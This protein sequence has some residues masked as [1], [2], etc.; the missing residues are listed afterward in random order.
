MI[1]A[2]ISKIILKIFILGPHHPGNIG[3]PD[4]DVLV[5]LSREMGICPV[6]LAGR[7]GPLPSVFDV[8]LD[9]RDSLETLIAASFRGFMDVFRSVNLGCL[10]GESRTWGSYDGQ[11]L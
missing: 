1:P 4:I 10:A 2:W 11:Q 9:S 8:R 5:S 6:C 3:K 7:S